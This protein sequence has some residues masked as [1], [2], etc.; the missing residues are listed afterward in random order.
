MFPAA[1]VDGYITTVRNGS[2]MKRDGI[3]LV[4]RH[5]AT[6]TMATTLTGRAG[7]VALSTDGSRQARLLARALATI[8]LRAVYSSPLQRA[9][10]TAQPIAAAHSLRVEITETL[11]EVD[12]GEWTGLTF[13]ALA[14]RGDWRAYNESR[15]SAVVPG[16][17]MP[18]QTQDRIVRAIADIASAHPGEIVAAVTHAEPVRYLILHARGEPLDRWADTDVAPASI[19]VVE[20]LHN[21]SI[22]YATPARGLPH[23]GLS[24]AHRDCR[25]SETN[26]R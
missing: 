24:R 6:H 3:V 2:D 7:G 12:F 5:A 9:I 25:V 18:H 11:N 4:I 21:H 15:A 17:E 14:R 22:A 26:P 16:G 8:P 10:E 20:R 19:T 1:V 23:C 13:A